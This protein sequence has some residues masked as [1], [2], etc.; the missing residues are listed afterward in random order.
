[1]TVH[2]QVKRKSFGVLV[3]QAAECGKEKLFKQA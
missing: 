1:M 3:R 2:M